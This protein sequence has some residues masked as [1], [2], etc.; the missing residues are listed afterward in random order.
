MDLNLGNFGILIEEQD[1]SPSGFCTKLIASNASLTNNG[2]GSFTLTTGGGVSDH[3]ALTGKLD[4]DHTQYGLLAGRA[5]GQA[6]IGGAAS[7]EGLTLNSTAHATKGLI[8]IGGALYVDEVNGR[9][10][11]G[12][13]APTADFEINSTGGENI[14]IYRYAT[15]AN[16]PGIKF[17]KA[18]GTEGSPIVA[19]DADD[20]G[21][22]EFWGYA[23]N[24]GDTDDAF[25]RTGMIIAEVDGVDA[26]GRIGGRIEFYTSAGVSV[27][28]GEKF[29]IGKDN[30]E[31]Y[32]IATA[33][34]GTQYDSWDFRFRCSIWDTD[35]TQAEDRLIYARA[36]AGSGANGSEPYD[37][38]FYDNSDNAVLVINP[39]TP[40]IQ[41]QQYLGHI[42]D[43]N[44]ALE[45]N[46]DRIKYLAGGVV[47]VDIFETTQDV[48]YLGNGALGVGGT[49]IDVYIG[50]NN[51]LMVEGSSGDIT[52]NKSGTA[53]AGTQYDSQDI[54]LMASVWD[55]D[56]TQAED[57]NITL[58]NVGGSGADGSEPYYFAV[59]DNDSNEIFTVDPVNARIG[60]TDK[61]YHIGDTN[62]WIQFTG[63]QIELSA[64]GG[65]AAVKIV[66]ASE[67]SY[68]QITTSVGVERQ[69]V[70]RTSL[71]DD[72]T[73]S[74]DI[75]VTDACR[76]FIIS[77]NSGVVDAWA[78]FVLGGDGNVTLTNN[79]ANVVANADTDANL[80][81]GT[82]AA[83]EPL[84]IKNRLG[85]SRVIQIH[86]WFY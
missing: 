64:G 37:L 23:R 58:R 66:E 21:K 49:D 52:I 20:T 32:K 75:S 82:A 86:I 62:T 4:D 26:Q 10:G 59:L 13:N 43:S 3:G 42:G 67:L 25:V 72:A 24:Q 47:F 56:N 41:I 38:T 76:G 44:T 31:V 74:L 50:T 27:T 53:T 71:A 45:F 70:W 30:I 1:G 14:Y 73:D 80:C 46:E 35:N 63:D 9:I 22:F 36:N 65:N 54:N 84:T 15:S 77:S 18:R 8:S 34:A 16:P 61:L 79:S 17:W 6:L 68:V 83:Q 81:I 60:M 7:G 51:A 78:E 48:I 57:R 33:T 40:T 5:G 2:D 19:N 28:P 55:T 39:L 11:I 29:S 85:G 69:K 12:E